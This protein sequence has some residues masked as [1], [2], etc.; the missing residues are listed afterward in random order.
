MGIGRDGPGGLPCVRGGAGRKRNELHRANISVSGGAEAG[1]TRNPDV[2]KQQLASRIWATAN[3]MRSKIAAQEYKDYI[4]GL[5]FYKFLSDHEEQFARENGYDDEVIRRDFQET[6]AQTVDFL[7]TRLGYFIAYKDLFSTWLKMGSEFDVSNVRDALSAFARLIAPSHKKVFEKIFETLGNGLG[8][9]GDNAANQTKA[10][11]GLMYLIQDIPVDDHQD[12]DVLGFIYEYL[13][14]QFAARA[15]KAGEFYTPHEVAQFMAAVVVDHLKERD[16][17]TIYDPT[18]GSGSL[19]INIGRAVARHM[20]DPNAVK[21]YAQELIKSTYNL[22]RMNL[23]MRGILPSNIEVRN[24]DTLERDWPMFDE[25]NPD[26]TYEPLF[27]DAVVA[28][29]PYSQPWSPN[30]RENDPRFAGFGLAPKSKADLAF[31]LHNLYHLRPD[32]IMAIV[33]PHG[34][35]YRGKPGDGSEGDIRRTLVERG[36]IDAIVG[37]PSNIFFG[38]GIPT[39]VMVLRKNRERNGILMVDASMGFVKDGN[40]NR[41]RSSDVKRIV[42]TVTGHLDV[43]GYSRNVTLEE[44]RE[45][46]YILNI[47]RYVQNRKTEHWD[48][49][50]IMEG[51]IPTRELDELGAYW[52]VFR[53][54]RKELFEVQGNYARLK[55]GD[56]DAVLSGMPSVKAYASLAGQALDGFDAYLKR[57]LMENW[58]NVAVNAEEGKIADE[59]F[60]RVEGIP[61]IDKYVTYQLLDDEWTQTALDLEIMQMEGFG[62]VRGV[63]PHMVLKKKGEETIEEQDGWMGRILPFELVQRELFAEDLEAIGALARESE[64]LEAD[65]ETL[66]GEIPE[67]ERE[68]LMEEEGGEPDAKLL[69]AK[70]LEILADIETPELLALEAY[71]ALPCAAAK[72]LYPAMHPEVDWAAMEA[73]RTGLYNK[74]PVE[75]RMRT[76]R[77]QHEFPEDSFERQVLQA[78]QAF[79]RLKEVQS[80]RKT[81]E[82]KLEAKTIDRIHSL[83]DDEALHL[84]EAK[85]VRPLA[86]KLEAMPW[87]VVGNL[88]RQVKALAAKYATT[89]AEVS[90]EVAGAEKELY[91]LL[92]ELEGNA[93]D[94]AGIAEWKKELVQ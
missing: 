88:A 14:R 62:A 86:E 35:L 32:G 43:P 76:L 2:N 6:N 7:H 44:I 24:G 16:R 63:D 59:L 11:R 18:S 47:S 41:L 39:I 12:Y 83:T 42:D 29:P 52:Q 31:L 48:I 30:G 46:G 84:L 91:G 80:S 71:L 9:L 22:T 75:A 57:E 15:K 73:T 67:D 3:K 66:L 53:G 1:D 49:R 21:Y 74:K 23:V 25:M 58:E 68:R 85:W 51:G 60:R 81:L 36:H 34:V 28:N 4:L 10:L 5:I 87:N 69:K 8:Q 33:M 93:D 89:L 13:L 77:E 27:V 92:G 78:S 90:A 20:E 55:V 50:A 61:L 64:R 94:L 79:D 70:A 37:L 56:I 19:L 65:L 17:I 40:K 45:N 82:K 72:K 38:T 26:A 54:V